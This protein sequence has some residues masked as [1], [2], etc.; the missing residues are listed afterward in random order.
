MNKIKTIE[1][2]RWTLAN[3]KVDENSNK[4][5][6]EE[7]VI[8]NV[9]EREDEGKNRVD[10]FRSLFKWSNRGREGVVIGLKKNQAQH[11]LLLASAE[12]NFSRTHILFNFTL[13]QN[14]NKK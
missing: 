4:H 10:L 3:A 7:S 2:A 8:W 13:F 5:N 14:A 6:K 1:D 9:V 12:N 11:A